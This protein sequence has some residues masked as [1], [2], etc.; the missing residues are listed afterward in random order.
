MVT[1]RASTRRGVRNAVKFPGKAAVRAGLW[2]LRLVLSGVF[3]YAGALKL[4]DPHAF[5]ESIASFRLLPPRL[6]NPA[7]LTL[8]PLEILAAVIALGSGWW[9]R[10][11]TFSILVMLGVFMLALT[12]ALARGLNVDCGCFGADGFDVLAPSK[13]LWGAMLRDLALGT[14]AWVLYVAARNPAVTPG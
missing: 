10:V 7:A 5:S 6:I 9:R 11:G 12:T 1:N 4:R 8:P 2:L 14:S 3:I 13:N